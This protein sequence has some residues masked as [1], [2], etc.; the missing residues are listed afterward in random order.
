MTWRWGHAVVC[1]G[2]HFVGWEEW[3]HRNEDE[4]EEKDEEVV[5]AMMDHVFNLV[6]FFVLSSAI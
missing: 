6:Q 1:G 5:M 3:C 4:G 2:V